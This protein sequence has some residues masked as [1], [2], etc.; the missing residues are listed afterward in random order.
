[1]R[2]RYTLSGNKGEKESPSGARISTTPIASSKGFAAFSVY[3]SSSA[4]LFFIAVDHVRQRTG[5]FGSTRSGVQSILPL[6][7][8]TFANPDA[9][10]GPASTAADFVADP[11]SLFIAASPGMKGRTRSW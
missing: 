8:Q 10:E 1:M 7:H 3:S 11:M 5:V 2:A 4:A 9:V 6:Q